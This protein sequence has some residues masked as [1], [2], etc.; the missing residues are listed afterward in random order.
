[1][2]QRKLAAI[3]P[4]PEL[5]SALAAVLRREGAQRYPSAEAFA[6]DLDRYLAWKPVLA[7]EGARSD[8]GA[9][10]LE[11][12]TKPLEGLGRGVELSHQVG[13]SGAVLG[14]LRVTDLRSHPSLEASTWFGVEL[15][16]D[17]IDSVRVIDELRIHANARGAGTSTALLAAAFEAGLRA[18]V[19]LSLIACAPA[20]YPDLVHLGFRAIGRVQQVD[21]QRTIVPMALAHHDLE[22]L[23]RVGSPL[24]AVLRTHGRFGDSRAAQWAQSVLSRRIDSGPPDHP[25]GVHAPLSAGLSA[26]LFA[27]LFA[28]LSEQGR[29]ELVAH[30]ARRPGHPGD[31]LIQAG[32]R[33]RWIAIVEVG[34]VEIVIGD[35]VLA[36]RGPGELIGE[37]SFLLDKPRTARVVVA[38]PGTSL[39]VIDPDA[40][41]RLSRASDRE[42]LWR[43]LAVV[44]ARKLE[45][46]TQTRRP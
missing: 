29:A 17:L 34:L 40:I 35:E 46:Q 37:M 4:P 43:N 21:E 12:V 3:E 25:Q 45:A 1:L 28:G 26:G 16:A 23:V 14:S 38:A 36:V 33:G 8:A 27:G 32:E 22:Q 44:L 11:I 2:A 31:T 5:P 6:D 13:S 39:L 15:P 41:A 20:H 18:G 10:E 19:L 9:G 7:F 24:A 30:A 42:L